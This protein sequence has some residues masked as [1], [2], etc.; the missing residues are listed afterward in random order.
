VPDQLYID[1]RWQ[2]AADGATIPAINPATEET[3]ARVAAGADQAFLEIKHV[4]GPAR[5]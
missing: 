5:A 2:P 1:G 4:V 3:I